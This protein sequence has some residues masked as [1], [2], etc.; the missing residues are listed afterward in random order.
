V[1]RI[2]FAAC[3]LVGA[4]AC[5][6]SRPVPAVHYYTLRISTDPPL[7]LPAPVEVGPFTADAPYASARIAYRTSPYRLEYYLY[8]RWA[9]DVP[10]LVATAVRDH[11]QHAPPGAGAAPFIVTGHVRR[12]EEEDTPEGW[13]GTLVVELTVRREGRVVFERVFHESEPA[14]RRNP[15]AIAAALSRALGRVLD[16]LV[17]ALANEG[18]GPERPGRAPR[19]PSG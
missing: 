8:H 12:L 17:R 18:T 16:H 5:T 3:L 19:A 4:A 15:E 10:R 6:L 1:T 14:E 2:A 13:R 11:L 7:R 9:A